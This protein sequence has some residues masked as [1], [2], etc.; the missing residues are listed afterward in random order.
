MSPAP[1]VRKGILKKGNPGGSGPG[2]PTGSEG[3]PEKEWNLVGTREDSVNLL[4]K[5]E[6]GKDPTGEASGGQNP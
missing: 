4:K 5:F 3:N 2:A 1:I 6:G